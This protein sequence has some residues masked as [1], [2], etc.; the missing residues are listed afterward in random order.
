MVFAREGTNG[1]P[2]QHLK[3]AE[4]ST[5]TIEC[6]GADATAIN[7]GP[8]FPKG[9]LVAMSNGMTFHYYNWEVIQKIIN[10]KQ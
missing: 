4:V 1:N 3:L 10:G 9:M 8:Q 6:D 5:S 7:L 2:N